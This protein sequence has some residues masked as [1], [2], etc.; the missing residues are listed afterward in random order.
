MAHGVAKPNQLIKPF[1]TLSMVKGKPRETPRVAAVKPFLFPECALQG[2]HVCSRR[3][4]LNVNE[5]LVFGGM[6]G[7]SVTGASEDLCESDVSDT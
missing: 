6:P 5:P 3:H 2:S 4:A 1:K 7:K